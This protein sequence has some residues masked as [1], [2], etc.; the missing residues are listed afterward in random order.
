VLLRSADLD[1]DLLLKRVHEGHLAFP[2]LTT[3]GY[4]A[5]ELHAPIPEPVLTDLRNAAARADP[6]RGERALGA[7]VAGT[8]GSVGRLLRIGGGWG[9]RLTVAKWMAFPSRRYVRSIYELTH[10]WQVPLYYL[11]RPL[12]Y[13]T[14]RLLAL[15]G[16]HGQA[17]PVDARTR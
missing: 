2:L 5:E 16:T 6:L 10:P 1:W 13:V 15:A 14:R 3:L 7:A 4:L 9:P 8:S 12:R 17:H 11:Y